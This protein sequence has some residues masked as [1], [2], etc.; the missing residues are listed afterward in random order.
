MPSKP[1]KPSNF[2]IR[3]WSIDDRPREKMLSKGSQQLT[4]AE[5][6]AL[7]IG[8]G[9]QGESA[10]HLMQR[11]LA[12]VNNNIG[13]LHRLALERLMEWKGIG[14]AKAVKIKAALELGKRIDI[15]HSPEQ[16]ECSNSQL[17]YKLFKPVLS[18]LAH[19]EIWAA[20]L[21][22]QNKV[23][24]H[25][26]IGKGGITATI[27]DLRVVFKKALEVG[28]T[29]LLIAHNHPTGNVQ[30]SRADITL[31][32]KIKKGA[33]TLDIRLLDHLIVSE[34]G[35]FSFADENLL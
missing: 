7:L 11:L 27:L 31:T 20:Y 12:S 22:S 15:E 4:N 34:K 8:S 9:N 10:V 5:L 35:Y 23:I 14:P 32:K 26:C 2:T 3:E 19:E 18:F 24:T 1:T 21:N 25:H 28:A 33:L 29:G 30:P 6:L 16:L 17:S 13:E